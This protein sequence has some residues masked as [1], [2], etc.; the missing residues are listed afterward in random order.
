MSEFAGPNA[1]TR[2]HTQARTQVPARTRAHTHAW[3]AYTACR[4]R[5]HAHARVR[6]HTHAYR[7]TVGQIGHPSRIAWYSPLPPHTCTSPLIWAQS[8]HFLHISDI[9]GDF[10]PHR[11]KSDSSCHAMSWHSGSNGLPWQIRTCRTIPGHC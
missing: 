7:G 11:H 9:R 1:R 4:A 10:R 3:L 2:V 6:A 8:A 5:T